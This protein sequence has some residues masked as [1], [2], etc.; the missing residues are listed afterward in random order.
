MD[1]VGLEWLYTMTKREA[2]EDVLE[3]EHQ[4]RGRFRTPLWWAGTP[5]TVGLKATGLVQRT[6]CRQIDEV[7][8]LSMMRS[9][10]SIAWT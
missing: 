7:E 5:H 10:T 4:S 9:R 2:L 1:L 6:S 3:W 8:D